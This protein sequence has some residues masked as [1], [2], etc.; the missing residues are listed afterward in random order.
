MEPADQPWKVE[1]VD[2][3]AL[4]KSLKKTGPAQIRESLRVLRLDLE[5]NGL[6]V[7]ASDKAK[8][9]GGGLAEYRY[10]QDPSIL[11]RLFFF[12]YGNRC[13]IVLSA[14]NKKRDSSHS[15]QQAEIAKARKIMDKL[16]GK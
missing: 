14:Y 15:R 2:F 5:T 11:I 8:W 6:N 9:L 13:F 3:G 10:R 12:V 1:F 7:F 4:A 16:I